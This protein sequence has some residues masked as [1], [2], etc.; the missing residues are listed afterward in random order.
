MFI[1]RLLF[2]V[3][4]FSYFGHYGVEQ[5]FRSFFFGLLFDTSSLV[6]FN[7]LF[8]LL[9]ILPFHFRENNSYQTTLK[10]LFV[11][12]NAIALLLNLIDI[13][14]FPFSGKRTG[15]ELSG[16]KG[17]ILP[18][19]VNYISS[20][21]Y[22]TLIL[23]FLIWVIYQC[24]PIAK[25]ENLKNKKSKNIL[26]EIFVMILFIGLSV[27]GARGGWNL[28]PLGTFDA[29]RFVRTEMVALTLN[30]PFQMINTIQQVGVSEKNYLPDDIAKKYFNPVHQP[31][32]NTDRNS[33]PNIV[34][35]IV[36]SLGKEDVGFYNNGEGF[37][38]FLDSLMKK[39][40]VYQHAYANGKR[41]IE[42]LPSIIASMPSL[43]EN[44]YMNS[45]YQSNKLSSAGNYLQQTGY[46]ASF[47]HGGI[48][49]TMS[50]NNFVAVTNG[51]KYFGK[52]EYPNQND[53]DGNWGIYDEPYLQYFANELA[54]KPQPF[55]STV[56]TLSSHHPYNIPDDK[57][58]L[59]I[60]GKLPIHK[61]IRY[62]DYSLK[63][64]FETAQKMPWFNNTV[65]II[66]ADHSA[67]NEKPR[68]QTFNGM[69]EIPLV[70]YSP[71]FNQNEITENT[72]TAQQIDI[73]PIILKYAQYNK[74]YFSFGNAENKK[75]FAI[76]H[77]GNV[78]QLI[79]W[80]YV[81]LFTEDNGFGLFNL[82]SDPL[83]NKNL[84]NDPLL[85]K[86]KLEM[87]TIIK[88]VIQQYNHSLITNSTFIP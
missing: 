36:E 80:P 23:I 1:S 60:E 39:S 3:F 64:F 49:G 24:Y 26:L 65:F 14:Y 86:T 54:H 87:D 84:Y 52:N 2:F 48:N 12:I 76:Q 28:K 81:Y 5:I 8:I 11:S 57:K 9:H 19:V 74:K 68:Y 16:M 69:F 20:F 70:I 45:Y 61:A 62:T 29:A 30:T 67:E 18:H 58:N 15:L 38:P 7:A 50:F 88:S 17:D 40:I 53:Y 22:L 6:Y 83:S 46:D 25:P 72:E 85:N 4:N 55:L 34:L 21:W 51:G 27:L 42:G 56:F 33:K 79:C 77:F 73:L 63:R 47:Y 78:Y 32:F 37:T 66:T 44:D 75:S 71:L 35:I 10:V 31:L 41:S 59:F 13:G 43:M 82:S